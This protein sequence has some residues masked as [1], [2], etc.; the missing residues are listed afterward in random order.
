M[1]IKIWAKPGLIAA[2][3]PAT[4]LTTTTNIFTVFSERLF[5]CSWWIFVLTL[6]ENLLAS[7]LVPFAGLLN[8][9]LLQSL[10][11]SCS[12]AGC[13][14]ASRRMATNVMSPSKSPETFYD[15][16]VKVSPNPKFPCCL[17]RPAAS[18]MRDQRY[19]CRTST[20]MISI[21]ITTRARWYCV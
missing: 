5:R 20:G 7:V 10:I 8:V 18:Q 3:G 19:T 6:L 13:P 21:L 4:H 2:G 15:F 16:T 14:G 9:L 12:A 1:Q 11:I 17:Q